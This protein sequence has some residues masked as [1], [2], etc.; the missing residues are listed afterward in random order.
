MI[1]EE[2]YETRLKSWLFHPKCIEMIFAVLYTDI[3]P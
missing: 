3:N 2:V 1:P